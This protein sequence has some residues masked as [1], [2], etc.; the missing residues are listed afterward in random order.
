MGSALA[1]ALALP[2]LSPCNSRG[3]DPKG[4]SHGGKH[5]HAAK[6]AKS[7]DKAKENP[8][9]VAEK[10][11]HQKDADLAITNAIKNKILFNFL[12]NTKIETMDGVVTLTGS[13]ANN[14]ERDLNTK[15]ASKISGVKK[16]VNLMDVSSTMVTSN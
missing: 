13:A 8:E 11:A 6:V 14:D 9:A 3:A 12:L 4:D 10:E 1:L 5:S 7:H 2:F 15:L 16:V